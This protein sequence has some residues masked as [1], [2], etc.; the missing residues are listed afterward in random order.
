[1]TAEERFAEMASTHPRCFW[2]DAGPGN[3]GRSIMGALRDD[4]IS[5]TYDAGCVTTSPPSRR[6]APSFRPGR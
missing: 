2:L 4:D 3:P 5:L 6:C 1:M